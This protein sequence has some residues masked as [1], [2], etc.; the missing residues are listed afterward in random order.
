LEPPHIGARL[1]IRSGS[2]SV[3]RPNADRPHEI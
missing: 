3:E 1:A 2:V